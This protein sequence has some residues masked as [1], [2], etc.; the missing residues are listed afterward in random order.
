MHRINWQS[1]PGEGAK[2]T[3]LGSRKESSSSDVNAYWSVLCI[4]AFFP[5]AEQKFTCY[6][7]A[8]VCMCMCMCVCMRIPLLSL[9]WPLR[10]QKFQQRLSFLGQNILVWTYCKH[11]SRL[12]YS[13]ICAY[14]SSRTPRIELSDFLH[15]AL[16]FMVLMTTTAVVQQRW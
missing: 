3:K 15:V 14:V 8:R 2:P 16:C 10:K 7:R 12:M 1:R 13:S 9:S 4:H 5:P 11:V 6:S